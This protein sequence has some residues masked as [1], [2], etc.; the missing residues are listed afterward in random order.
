V[1]IDKHFLRQAFTL[2]ELLVVIAI[3][4]ILIA[5][6]LPAVQQVREAARRV[7]CLNNMRQL[8]LAN[9]NFE[10]AYQHLPPSMVAPVQGAFPTSNGSWG[11][12]GR[13]MPF[14]E[15]ENA[16]RLVNLEVGYDQPPN[17]TSGIPQ[18][19]IGT[20]ICP[21]EI[22]DMPRL[23]SDGSV[24]SYP[25]NYVF[26]FGT[27]FV[28][29]PNTGEGGDGAYH[30]NSKHRLSTF[31][32]GTSSTLMVSEA[33]VFTPYSRNLTGAS[34]TPPTTPEEV[35]AYVLAAPD[36]KMSV[37]TNGNTGHTEWPDGAIH[38]AGFTTA[39]APNTNVRVTYNDVLYQ[40]CDF[41][42]QAEGRSATNPTVAAITARSYHSGGMIN[43]GFVDG[44]VRGISQTIDLS[45]WRA[46]GTRAGGEVIGSY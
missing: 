31:Y 11:I 40:H 44:S 42:S 5:M 17:S 37:D 36:K 18:M 6:L 12:L 43:V 20:F 15:Q 2:I 34:M 41:N 23:K 4:G 27:W 1:L 26:N 24:H 29:N 8:A 16:S 35:G 25:L 9:H 28:W 3:I 22:N 46:L 10:S 7:S 33:R 21:S 30:P 14:I 38:H 39:M 32:D 45:L 19:K 13:I